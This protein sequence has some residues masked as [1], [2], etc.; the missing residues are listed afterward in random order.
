MCDYSLEGY[1]N[2]PA[3]KGELLV[4]QTFGTGTN[5]FASPSNFNQAV[6][7]APGTEVSLKLVPLWALNRLHYL[8]PITKDEPKRAIFVKKEQPS[9]DGH[10]DALIIEGSPDA[11][12]YLQ[13]LPVDLGIEVLS[14]PVPESELVVGT[15][16]AGVA[17]A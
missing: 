2:R 1:P 14:V 4:L 10:H 8:K 13:N 16:P 11:A 12:V 15:V 6:C 7:L 3:V 17:S 5:A 9:P